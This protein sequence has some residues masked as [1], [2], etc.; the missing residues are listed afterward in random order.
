MV[1]GIDRHFTRARR[2]AARGKIGKTVMALF[3]I[4]VERRFAHVFKPAIAKR[5][6]FGIYEPAEDDFPRRS[7]RRSNQPHTRRNE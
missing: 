4:R 5:K 2:F 6:I 7:R 3:D 1:A